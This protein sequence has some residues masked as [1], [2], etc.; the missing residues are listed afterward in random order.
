CRLIDQ[1]VTTPPLAPAISSQLS[2]PIGPSNVGSRKSMS[3]Q[4]LFCPAIRQLSGVGSPT[5]TSCGPTTGTG[6]LS[7]TSAPPGVTLQCWLPNTS[8][9]RPSTAT[10]CGCHGL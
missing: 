5:F 1:R 2:E 8:S 6:S 7:C 4:T 9:L 3:L 10:P